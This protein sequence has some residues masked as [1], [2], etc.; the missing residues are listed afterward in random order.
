MAFIIG[1]SGIDGAGKTAAAELLTQH[2]RSEGLRVRYQH[3]LNYPIGKFLLRAVSLVMGKGRA[4]HAKTHLLTQKENNRRGLSF[5]YHL[6]I[7]VD[8]LIMYG[9]LR[10]SAG[11]VVHDRWPYDTH[12]QFRT[13]NYDNRLIAWMFSHFPRPDQLLLLRVSAR[14]AYK[15]KRTDPGHV[16]DGPE[17]FEALVGWMAELESRFRYDAVI[18]AESPI[19]QV[20]DAIHESIGL[21]H[22]N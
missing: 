5:L 19:E 7:F 13:R 18:D 21:I 15:R 10:L 14:T 11:V 4:E 20:V 1:L 6:L 9:R 16:N 17:Y 3:E 22:V 12:L 8:D 2:L